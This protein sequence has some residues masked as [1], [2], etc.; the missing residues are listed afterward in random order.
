MSRSHVKW[1]IVLTV[2]ALLMLAAPA[3]AKGPG[4]GGGLRW[5]SHEQ[6][7]LPGDRGGCGFTINTVSP[8]VHG[9]VHG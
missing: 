9:A 4:G 1:A 3:L 5:T 8:V 6:P 7:V 2:I